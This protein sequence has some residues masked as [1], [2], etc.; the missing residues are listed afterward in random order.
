MWGSKCVGP[1]WNRSKKIGIGYTSERGGSEG[2]SQRFGAHW[3]F[4]PP[5]LFGPCSPPFSWALN[6]VRRKRNP[7]A[8][9]PR[10]SFIA[11][12]PWALLPCVFVCMSFCALPVSSWRWLPDLTPFFCP[13][14][15][16]TLSHCKG[17]WTKCLLLPPRAGTEHG[18][19][20]GCTRQL[21]SSLML[22]TFEEKGPNN[23]SESFLLCT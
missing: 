18:P 5:P 16:D 3:P 22:R 7:S 6:R 11:A 14:I 10:Y 23:P 19:Q 20:R 1:G 2:D 21:V 4:L 15:L 9:D 17:S 12:L 13:W 8:P